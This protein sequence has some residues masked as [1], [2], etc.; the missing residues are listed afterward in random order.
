MP[1]ETPDTGADMADALQLDPGET[2]TEGDPLD[3][4]YSP[5]DRPYA[6]E[7]PAMTGTA[8][9]LDERLSREL[10]EESGPV[11]D[12]RTGRLAAAETGADGSAT[13]DA[14]AR[15]VG[16]DGGAAAAEEAA[17]HDTETGIEPVVDDSPAGDP[18]VAEALEEEERP[19]AAQA[20]AERDY[21]S[22]TPPQEPGAR[23]IDANPDTGGVP[24]VDGARDAGVTPGSWR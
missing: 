9:T 16:V 22:E 23:R 6:V 17:V 11:D 5:P 14:D 24:D 20:D 7:D 19:A 18:E 10:P 1:D 4:G 13:D 3:A 12:D 2:L 8:E 21:R 15:D